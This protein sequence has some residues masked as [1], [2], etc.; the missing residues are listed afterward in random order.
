MNSDPFKSETFG[1]PKK[2]RLLHNSKIFDKGP[3]MFFNF[4]LE[5]RQKGNAFLFNSSNLM[6]V[7]LKPRS[8]HFRIFT[9]NPGAELIDYEGID[10][11]KFA[12]EIFSI[13]NII[14]WFRNLRT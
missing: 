13:P 11:G 14:S 8:G 2:L 5:V 4:D 9:A 12:F 3:K 1:R 7:F 6:K 10:Q